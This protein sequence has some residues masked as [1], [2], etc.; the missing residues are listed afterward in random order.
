MIT[1]VLTNLFDVDTEL[2]ESDPDLPSKLLNHT[3]QLLD[4]P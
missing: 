1:N 2:D 4:V 3:F